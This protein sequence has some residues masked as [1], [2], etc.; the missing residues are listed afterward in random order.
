MSYQIKR[1]PY[2]RRIFNNSRRNGQLQRL[3][4]EYERIQEFNDRT[5]ELKMRQ[6]RL[7]RLFREIEDINESPSSS[8][9]Q[10]QHHGL[11]PLPLTPEAQL[12]QQRRLRLESLERARELGQ[13]MSRR[14]AELAENGNGF[15]LRSE[16]RSTAKSRAADAARREAQERRQ[17]AARRISY[18][19]AQSRSNIKRIAQRRQRQEV[20]DSLLYANDNN[21]STQLVAELSQSPSQAEQQLHPD[22][23]K[24]SMLQQRLQYGNSR[25]TNNMMRSQI[26]AAQR[27][28]N[29]ISLPPSQSQQAALPAELENRCRARQLEM[30][31]Q[32]SP[33]INDNRMRS[34]NINRDVPLEMAY[35]QLPTID[36]SDNNNRNA[37]N[38]ESESEMQTAMLPPT[39]PSQLSDDDNMPTTSHKINPK[40]TTD[41]ATIS[42]FQS[43][44]PSLVL[45]DS[46]TPSERASERWHRISLTLPWFKVLAPVGPHDMPSSQLPQSISISIAEEL[47]DSSNATTTTTTTATSGTSDNYHSFRGASLLQEDLMQIMELS[48]S[49]ATV[50]VPLQVEPPVRRTFGN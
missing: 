34:N 49:Q 36:N 35:Q 47:P 16:L 22:L 38:F 42:G 29:C 13:E 12:E 46:H 43:P 20:I 17:R 9:Q 14:N 21:R 45:R 7:K 41:V 50:P 6:V 19:N 18:G 27:V 37:L 26:A 30:E 32:H 25:S 8:N 5:I 2:Y 33:S 15:Y 11:T 23:I 39:E 10:Q 48:D 44:R 1:T 28:I 4:E 3:R 24:R 31:Y 40:I